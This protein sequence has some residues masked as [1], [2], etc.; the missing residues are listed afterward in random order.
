MKDFRQEYGQYAIVTGASSG[1]GEEFARQLAAAGVNLI[2]VARRAARLERLSAELTRSHG[3]LNEVVALDLLEPGAVDELMRRTA[4]L[5]VG[6]LIA[7]AGVALAGPLV[8]HAVDDELDVFT[9]HGAVT[10]R[11]AHGFGQAFAARGRGALVLISS[12]IAAGAVPFQANYA[13]V[14]A[15]VL[16]LGQALH[17]ELK[18]TGVDVLVLAP[19]Q[20][21]TEGLGKIRGIDF[22]KMPG[23]AKM[24]PAKAVSAALHA[25]GRRAVVI[26]GAMNKVAD[27][28]SK[29]LMTRGAAARMY[30]SIIGR[31]LTDEARSEA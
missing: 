21:E 9:L 5:D 22:D 13:A 6:M 30:G 1:L 27:A 11:L 12:S 16:S 7:S 31:A 2:L 29:H 15:Y 23:G 4:H 20:T 3:T 17:Y 19:G 25:L 26:P 18:S 14:K 8:E 10:L 24:S 28:L